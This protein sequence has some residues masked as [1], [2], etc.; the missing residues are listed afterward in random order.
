MFFGII[1]FYGLKKDYSVN[2]E[3]QTNTINCGVRHKKI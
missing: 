3:I 1:F 2:G